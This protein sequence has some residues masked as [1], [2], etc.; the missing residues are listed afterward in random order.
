MQKVVD[1]YLNLSVVNDKAMQSECAANPTSPSCQGRVQDALNYVGDKQ[2]TSGISESMGSDI[3]RSR[4]VALDQTLN[5]GSYGAVNNINTRADF[6]GAMYTQTGAPWFQTAEG[7]S[8]NDLQGGLFDFGNYMSGGQ[9]IQWRDAAGSEILKYGFD[10]FLSIY[11]DPNQN[12]DQ[13]S[14]NQLVR[15]QNDPLLE[16]VHKQYFSVQPLKAFKPMMELIGGVNDLLSPS[17]RITAGCVHM[18]FAANCG[19]AR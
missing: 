4:V 15:E 6:F 17:D 2:E 14:V 9:M 10:N 11:N 12:V 5:D 13:W 16:A 3:N 7:V 19:S 1:E 8:R 18:G